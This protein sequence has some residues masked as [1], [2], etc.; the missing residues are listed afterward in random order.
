[1]PAADDW[2]QL[3]RQQRAQRGMLDTLESVH[4]SVHAMEVMSTLIK[5]MLIL[6]LKVILKNCA[7]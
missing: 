6:I 3:S 2:A 4:A 7:D 1:M 5:D